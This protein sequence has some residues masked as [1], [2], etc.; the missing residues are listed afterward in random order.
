MLDVLMC[1]LQD[2]NLLCVV[3]HLTS[4]CICCGAAAADA[5]CSAAI[6]AKSSKVVNLAICSCSLS[7]DLC[8]LG[9]ACMHHCCLNMQS[10][11]SLPYAVSEGML[12]T[13]I[14]TSKTRQYMQ[15]HASLYACDQTAWQQA[16]MMCRCTQLWS[17]EAPGCTSFGRKAC[18]T[19]TSPHCL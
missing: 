16:P 10:E 4:S 13:L 12:L 19:I 3:V 14:V 11:Q 17:S 1:V 7:Q 2:Q 8:D 18:I 6:T 5:F 9:A 15:V